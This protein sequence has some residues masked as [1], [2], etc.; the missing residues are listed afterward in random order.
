MRNGIIGEA[1]NMRW[2]AM[3][4]T[5]RKDKRPRASALLISLLLLA[6]VLW[7][8][9][10]LGAQTV[11]GSV[12]DMKLISPGSGWAL[13]AGRLFW[14]SDNGQNWD[15]ITPGNNQ[16]PVSKV[17]FLD[18]KT[19]W[20][21]LPWIS[22]AGT[23]ITVASTRNGGKSWQNVRVALDSIAQGRRVGGIASVSFVDAQQGWLILHLTSSSNFSIGAALHTADGGLTWTAL[24]SPPAAGNIAFT[25]SLDGWMAGGP[26]QDRL[27][28]THDGGSSWQLATITAPNA[29]SGSAAILN[30]P[31]FTSNSQGQLTASAATSD[32]NCATDYVTED[33]GQSWQAQQVSRGSAALHVASANAGRQTSHVYALGS[34][35]FIEQEGVLSQGSLPAGL[36]LNGTITH[37]EFI[38]DSSGWLSYSFGSCQLS[39]TLC[40]QQSELLATMDGGKTYSTITPHLAATQPVSSKLAIPSTRSLPSEMLLNSAAKPEATAGANT[41]VSNSSGIDLACAPA[42]S[43]MQTWWTNSPY[44][45]VGVYLGGCDVYCVSPN[46][47]NTCASNWHS[48]SSKTVDSNLTS[49]WVTSVKSQG[50]GILP[51]WVG[52]QSPCITNASSYWTINNSDTYSTGAYQADLAIAQA[53]AL[54]ITNGIIYYDMEGYTSDGGSCSS[55][56][57]IFLVSWTTELHANGFA[58]G[59]YGGVSAFETDF[60]NLS[61]LPDAIWVALWNSNNTV[62]NLGTLPNNDWPTNQRI[63]QWSSES[64]GETWGGVSLGGMDLNVVDAPVVG[65]WLATSPSFALSNSA[66]ITISTLGSNGTSTISVTPSSGFTGVVNLSCSISSSAAIPPTCSIPASVTITGTAASTATLTIKTVAPTSSTM[67]P[68]SNFFSV[69]GGPILVCL[70]L[71]GIPRRSLSWRRLFVVLLLAVSIGAFTGCGGSGSST[72]SG[73]GGGT[74]VG[75]TTLGSYTVTVIG[76]DQATGSIKSNTTVAV[77]VN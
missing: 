34:E 61:P 73:G 30:L 29:C 18:A 24:P 62:W 22:D 69:S 16:Q 43:S 41:V 64:S 55:A 23:S 71:S 21:I 45:D 25:S 76:I 39:K 46:G 2:I 9:G 75:G 28:F 12:E 8:Q 17:F 44:Q 4:S 51:L 10:T 47:Q 40:T 58:S 59:L 7:A 11:G 27:W 20:A 66:A 72:G 74:S 32:G 14:T 38:D 70:L 48:S 50:W 56:V 37:A 53:N 42:S 33:G 49:A 57:E 3:K 6:G 1:I 26:A 13:A 36:P 68:Q 35:V 15:E 19:G 67:L 5:P 52:P 60:V 31:F 54:G 77:T 63:H 65:N